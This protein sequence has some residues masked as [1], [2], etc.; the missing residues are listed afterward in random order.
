MAL[1]P[2]QVDDWCRSKLEQDRRSLREL[3]AAIFGPKK[4]NAILPRTVAALRKKA[5]R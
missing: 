2:K 3:S 4:I 1:D 5:K